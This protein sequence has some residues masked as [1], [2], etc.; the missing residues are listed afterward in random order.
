MCPR[1]NDDH[2]TV[3]DDQ[4]LNSGRQHDN[5]IFERLSLKKFLFVLSFYCFAKEI[6]LRTTT[7]ICGRPDFES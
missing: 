3:V 7:N 2:K 1:V 4:K 5:W 6:P